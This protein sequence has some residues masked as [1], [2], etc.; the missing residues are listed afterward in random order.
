MEYAIHLFRP[1]TNL[2]LK[3]GWQ[4]L[5]IPD[6]LQI[7]AGAKPVGNQG[8]DIGGYVGLEC[9]KHRANDF[10][11]GFEEDGLGDDVLLVRDIGE[12][13]CLG[14]VDRSDYF[15][16]TLEILL[17]AEAD[18][19]GLLIPGVEVLGEIGL[20]D[21]PRRRDGILELS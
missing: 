1:G 8:N 13:G 7:D 4:R 11:R 15:H 9:G 2:L 16:E 19:M 17:G 21:L 10:L 18:K 3:P 5:I 12:G 6:A 20:G 14:A